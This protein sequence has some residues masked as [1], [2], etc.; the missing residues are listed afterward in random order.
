MDQLK[1][2]L[3]LEGRPCWAEKTIIGHCVAYDM[4]VE[5][6]FLYYHIEGSDLVYRIAIE[7]DPGLPPMLWAPSGFEVPSTRT[8]VL[9]SQWYGHNVL[10]FD[11]DW[12]W[13]LPVYHDSLGRTC[14]ICREERRK[15]G[16][17]V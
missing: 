8:N 17:A 9:T 10:I 15:Q 2:N 7:N 16:L 11:H 14:V 6:G 3:S 4:H 13:S 12:F 5:D 1:L